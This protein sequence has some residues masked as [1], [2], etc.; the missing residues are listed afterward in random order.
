MLLLGMFSTKFSKVATD[1]WYHCIL[2]LCESV[3]SNTF[4]RNMFLVKRF[5]ISIIQR[6]P[7]VYH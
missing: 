3:V 1:L 7:P 5:L 6:V 2:I 4:L